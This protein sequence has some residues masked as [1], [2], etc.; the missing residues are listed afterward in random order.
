MEIIIAYKRQVTGKNN[1][2]ATGTNTEFVS[3]QNKAL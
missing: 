2:D 3:S 1:R